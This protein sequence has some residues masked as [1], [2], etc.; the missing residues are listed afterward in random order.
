MKKIL[1]AIL[2]VASLFVIFGCT[3]LPVC[4]NGLCEI[5]EDVTCV[6]DCGGSQIDQTQARAAWK[7]A[8]PWAIVDWAITG[9]SNEFFT[10]VVLNNSN[11]TLELVKFNLATD[12][13]LIFDENTFV[14]PGK[15][16][17]IDI[18]KQS[19]CEDG[20]KYIFDKDNI[21]LTYNSNLID[22]KKQFG[23]ADIIFYEVID[24]SNIC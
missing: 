16:K 3:Q 8:E 18:P 21:V 15:S 1:I 14:A 4:G 20:K 22:G 2:F 7:S 11:E 19:S 13:E 10:L 23:A 5:G 24:L 9:K 12:F 6:S 17:V